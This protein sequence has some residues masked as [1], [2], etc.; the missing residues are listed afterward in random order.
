MLD[1]GCKFVADL[2][3]GDNAALDKVTIT[4]H[5]KEGDT[6]KTATVVVTI[7]KEELIP[8]GPFLRAYLLKWILCGE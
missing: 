1:N 7:V 8:P 5:Y 2:K 4:F 6:D 3:V